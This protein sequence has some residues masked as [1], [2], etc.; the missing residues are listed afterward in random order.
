MYF[1]ILF[2]VFLL[3]NLSF[4]DVNDTS[5]GIATVQVYSFC[6]NKQDD[7]LTRKLYFKF[8]VYKNDSLLVEIGEFYDKPAI[9]S[10]PFGKYKF[11]FFD[12]K[13]WKEAEV[14]I[15]SSFSVINA[16]EL[17]PTKKKLPD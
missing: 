1:I 9:L 8:K 13:Q 14:L 4:C 16:E 17:F 15:L 6:E 3:T 11:R 2:F 7:I 12:S 5:S 10:L